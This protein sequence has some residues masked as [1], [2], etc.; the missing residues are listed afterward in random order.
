MAQPSDNHGLAQEQETLALAT[1][2]SGPIVSSP[3]AP[4]DAASRAIPDT[5]ARSLAAL[6]AVW[7]ILGVAEAIA[8]HFLVEEG[9]LSS[10]ELSVW[11]RAS[12]ICYNFFVLAVVVVGV[13]WPAIWLG[14]I[15]ARKPATRAARWAGQAL[16]L[17]ASLFVALFYITSWGLYHSV[18]VFFGVETFWMTWASPVQ[19][20]QH[21][22]QLEPDVLVTVPLLA[23]VV[24]PLLLWI[25]ARVHASI[26]VAKARRLAVEWGLLV[27]V[28]FGGALAGEMYHRGDTRPAFFPVTFTPATIGEVYSVVRSEHL[29]PMA[30]IA[31]VLMRDD[32]KD[33]AFVMDDTRI[34]IDKLGLSDGI[35]IERRPQV[36]MDDYLATAGDVKR[37]NVIVLLV[38]SLRSDQITAC[39]AKRKVMPAVESLADEGRVFA[40]NYSQDTY[41]AR[42]DMCPLSSQYP[43]R[44]VWFRPYPRIIPYPRVLI[45]DIL[46]PLGFRTAVFSSQNEHW[47]GMYNYLNTGSIDHFLHSDTY[48]GDTYTHESDH[49]FA[50]WAQKTGRSGKID[51][52]DTVDEAIK[53]IGEWK[54]E[55]FCIY[56]NLQASHVPYDPPRDFPRRFGPKPGSKEYR[57]VAKDVGFGGFP[58]EYTETVWDM[59]SDSLAYVDAQI[60]RLFDHLKATDQWDK[61]IV[62]VSG[63]AGEAFYEHGFASHGNELYEESVRVPL[64]IRAPGLEAGVDRELSQHVDVPPSICHLLGIPPHPSFQGLDLF[65]GESRANRSVYLLTHSPLAFQF[66]LVRNEHKLIYDRIYRHYRLYD[67]M[68][69]PG[70]H[71]DLS[72]VEPALLGEMAARLSTWRNAQIGYYADGQSIVNEYPPVLL[73]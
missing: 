42:A 67:L 16:F 46:K 48:E 7:A 63:D 27:S 22:V 39:G 5:A 2:V 62:V 10:F 59:Y 33:T 12:L 31:A 49:G 6:G 34:F 71:R 26:N 38:E 69:D 17:V 11:D 36:A 18:G 52:R 47:Q 61:T 28:L 51:D 66:A 23:M 70:E 4:V 21:V 13:G 72:D 19:M 3:A 68:E 15:I 32:P 8:M 54:D 9:T 29:S 14:R 58:R 53:W 65:S 60:G 56:M 40:N 45:H 55:P 41:S 35:V 1:D 20:L 44:E 64:I 57:K 30:H 25:T 24:G 50:T 37:W 43:L 73:D